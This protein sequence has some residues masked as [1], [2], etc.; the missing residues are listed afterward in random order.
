M[1]VRVRRDDLRVGETWDQQLREAE[2]DLFAA[3][4]GA[5]T[6]ASPQ[7]QIDRLRDS[8]ASTLSVVRDLAAE[9]TP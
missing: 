9:W 1:S 7:A 8:L 6:G 4:A 5:D 2:A 3:A